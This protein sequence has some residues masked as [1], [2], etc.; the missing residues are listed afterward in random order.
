MNFSPF[1]SVNN[2]CDETLKWSKGKLVQMGL[3]PL[4]TF[5]LRPARTN[6]DECFCPNQEMGGCNC[7]LVVLLVYG[8]GNIPETLMLYGNGVKT[9]LSITD[10]LVQ[11]TTDS[12]AEIIKDILTG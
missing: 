1:L 8:D 10:S 2:S 12:L 11:S 5:K 6:P 9:W 3:R 7:Q 4:Q